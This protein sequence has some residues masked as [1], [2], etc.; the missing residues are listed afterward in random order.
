MVGTSNH[1]DAAMRSSAVTTVIII[2]MD[3]TADTTPGRHQLQSGVRNTLHMSVAL[4]KS[5]EEAHEAVE[6]TTMTMTSDE[7]ERAT[8]MVMH[9][10][11]IQP[12]KQPS[13]RAK[14]TAWQGAVCFHRF[15]HQQQQQQL[16]CGCIVD[17]RAICLSSISTSLVVVTGHQQQRLLPWILI[18]VMCVDVP[19]PRATTMMVVVTLMTR[20]ERYTHTRM[21]QKRRRKPSPCDVVLLRRDRDSGQH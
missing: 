7:G 19:S 5:V 18:D 16:M 21:C 20:P 14:D 10:A 1:S 2:A 13:E 15:H 9:P 4:T 12:T 3:R 6:L 17:E 8:E 11:S